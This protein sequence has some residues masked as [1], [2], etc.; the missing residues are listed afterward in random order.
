MEILAPAGS[1]KS[2]LS[3]INAGA[4]AIY[5]G[6]RDITHQRSRCSNFDKKK[7]KKITKIAH[8]NDVKIH[9]TFNSS[10][11]S[12]NF[13]SIIKKMDFLDKINIDA[14]IISDIGLVKL[15]KKKYSNIKIMFSVQGQCA[16]S[17]FASLLK[18]LGVSRII[19]DRNISIKEAKTIKQ[20][21]DIEV[22][23]FL[24]GY[25]CYSQDS[26]CY[27]GD[28]FCNEPCNVQGANKIKFLDQF[29]EKLKEPKRY[30]FM[31][32]MSALNYIPE[33]IEAGIDCGKIEGRQR[34]SDYVKRTVRVFKEASDHYK[35]C[36]YYKKR[37]FIIKKKWIKD[38]KFAAYGFELTDSFYKKNDFKRTII[39]DAS[40]RNKLIYLYDI[41]YNFLETF[42]LTKLNKEI[43]SSLKIDKIIP[44]KKNINKHKISAFK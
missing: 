42:N 21:A 9:V 37:K 36:A 24:F 14:V 43:F 23:I 19:L 25:Q 16:N 20:K 2:A 10:Y 15:I 11:N 44:K 18:K 1:V 12:K 26:I 34:S 31:K 17:E 27:L 8:E 29:Q 40:L 5:L 39:K 38:L 4:D 3:A 33:I 13:Q 7:L 30:F 6:M 41:L 35:N 22:E 32:F 28:Y